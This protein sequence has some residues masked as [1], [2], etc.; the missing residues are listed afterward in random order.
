VI[1]IVQVNI[2][3]FRHLLPTDPVSR[4]ATIKN[5][6]DCRPATRD[7][8]LLWG[9]PRITMLVSFGLI[10]GDAVLADATVLPSF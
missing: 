8:V 4:R 7:F 1:F 10:N 6:L 9:F 5:V 2:E 3:L